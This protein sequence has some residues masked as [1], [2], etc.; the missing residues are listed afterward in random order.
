MSSCTSTRIVTVPEYHEVFVHRQDTA[1]LRDSIFVHDS[2]C[3][4]QRGDTVFIEKYNIV[5]RDRWR[6]RLRVDSFI[7]R[8]TVTVVKEV[9]KPPN[10]WQ[11][12]KQRLGS[13]LLWIVAAAAIFFLIRIIINKWKVW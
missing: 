3:I 6:D 8:D 7:Q 2:I 12:M 11:L 13:T 1:S 9:E 10:R 5:Y 4:V